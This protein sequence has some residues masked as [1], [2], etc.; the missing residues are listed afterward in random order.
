MLGPAVV[1]VAWTASKSFAQYGARVGALVALHT[2][3]DERKRIES[4]LGFSCRGTWSN[5]NHLGLLAITDLLSEPALK[6]R[7]DAERERLIR[8]LDER[9]AIYNSEAGRAGLRYPRYEGG[10]FVTVFTAGAARA[11]A[12]MR[13]EGVYAV[14]L[15]GALRVAL[16]STPARDVPRLVRALREGISRAEE[17]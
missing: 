13:E 12:A 9:V 16:C 2:E 3:A 6:A 5:C 10:F 15:E 7:A 11:A 14:P 8:L 17:R 4:A 1:L